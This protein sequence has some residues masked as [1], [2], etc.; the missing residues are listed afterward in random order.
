MEVRWQGARWS[1]KSSD[2]KLVWAGQSGMDCWAREHSDLKRKRKLLLYH[3]RTASNL[4]LQFGKS[5]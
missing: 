2:S 5:E 1:W 4:H 3:F